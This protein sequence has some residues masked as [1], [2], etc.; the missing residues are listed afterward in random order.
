LQVAGKASPETEHLFLDLA[1][2]SDG[3]WIRKAVVVHANDNNLQSDIGRQ[4]DLG[5]AYA[6]ERDIMICA[7]R[8]T[9]M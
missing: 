5:T 3:N 6:R 9:R 8:K 4:K 2:R 1:I 7:Y